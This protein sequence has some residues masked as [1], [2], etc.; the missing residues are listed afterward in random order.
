LVL[1]EP[2]VV[3]RVVE[4][5]SKCAACE[6]RK[7]LPPQTLRLSPAEP[8]QTLRLSP[9]PTPQSRIPRLA[10]GSKSPSSPVSPVGKR[11]FHRQD[12]YTKLH[13]EPVP[14]EDSDDR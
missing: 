11:P 7:M 3:E 13:S 12:T 8:P 9:S 2:S 14:E 10:A 4:K 1:I 6:T 5:E